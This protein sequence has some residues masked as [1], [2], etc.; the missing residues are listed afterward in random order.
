MLMEPYKRKERKKERQ[1]HWCPFQIK[2][3]VWVKTLSAGFWCHRLMSSVEA[4]HYERLL[5]LCGLCCLHH[6]FPQSLQYVFVYHFNS[7]G[8]LSPMWHITRSLHGICTGLCVCVCCVHI[9]APIKQ[10][11]CVLSTS[12]ILIVYAAKGSRGKTIGSWKKPRARIYSSCECFHI[13]QPKETGRMQ[14]L[15]LVKHTSLAE[16]LHSLTQ[17]QMKVWAHCMTYVTA[18]NKTQRVTQTS[19]SR[20]N[21]SAI[22]FKSLQML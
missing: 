6:I 22:R 3:N 10:V 7:R 17:V 5:S 12:A 21:V 20:L 18:R 16:P 13:S 19:M 15:L 4:F 14:V 11:V 8:H 2:H 1:T 9:W